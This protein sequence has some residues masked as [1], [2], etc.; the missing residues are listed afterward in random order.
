VRSNVFLESAPGLFHFH[1]TGYCI[2][3]EAMVFRR[4]VSVESRT[5]NNKG[6]KIRFGRFN[7]FLKKLGLLL[8]KARSFWLA[9]RHLGI[10]SNFTILGS[11]ASFALADVAFRKG[12]G[13]LITIIGSHRGNF[14]ELRF[15]VTLTVCRLYAH[16]VSAR[17]A[18]HGSDII[19]LHATRSR[20]WINVRVARNSA[21]AHSDASQNGT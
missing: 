6:V 13:P 14:P 17:T 16:V 15:S 10:V 2:L 5:Q 9:R 8:A 20:G 21:R 11:S 18:F 12:A 19:A 3:P 7:T 4:I 1:S